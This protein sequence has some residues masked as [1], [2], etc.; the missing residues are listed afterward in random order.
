MFDELEDGSPVCEHCYTAR[1][2]EEAMWLIL[3][4]IGSDV[5]FQAK[6]VREGK[7]LDLV[8]DWIEEIGRHL[9]QLSDDLKAHRDFEEDMDERLEDE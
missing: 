4:G 1:D 8:A 2:L 3:G 5:L 7:R 9:E 6:M